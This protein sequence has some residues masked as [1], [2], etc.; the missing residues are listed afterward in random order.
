MVMKISR[1]GLGKWTEREDE[2]DDDDNGGVES[3]TAY[4][5]CAVFMYIIVTGFV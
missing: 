2:E 5:Q 4:V 3:A 1:V